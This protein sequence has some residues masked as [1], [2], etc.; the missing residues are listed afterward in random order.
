[1]MTTSWAISSNATADD[2]FFSDNPELTYDDNDSGSRNENNNN[3]SIEASNID[4]L[5]A[6]ELNALTF[7]E[8]QSINEEIHGVN[9]N[10]IYIE[11]PE[12]LKESFV[13]LQTELNILQPNSFAYNR[14][15]ELYGDNSDDDDNDDNNTDVGEERKK[16]VYQYR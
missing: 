13:K 14:C 6:K 7:Q 15:Q 3:N 16:I 12:L 5:L 8:R 11:E 4:K 1:M 9:V 10:Q 2:D